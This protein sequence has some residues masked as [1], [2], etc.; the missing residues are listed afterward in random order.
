[1]FRLTL[2]VVCTEILIM[3]TEEELNAVQRYFG[4]QSAIKNPGESIEWKNEHAHQGQSSE[5]LQA[6]QAIF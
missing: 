1:M 6:K 2:A 5:H 4:F 3:Q